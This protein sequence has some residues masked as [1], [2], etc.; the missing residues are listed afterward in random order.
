MAG[1][2]GDFL[3][4][5]VCALPYINKVNKACQKFFAEFF[6]V[7]KTGMVLPIQANSCAKHLLILS[8]NKELVPKLINLLG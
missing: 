2:H 1:T 8:P 3:I 5:K 7:S 4:M 6:K